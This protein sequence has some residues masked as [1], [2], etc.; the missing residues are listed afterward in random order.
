MPQYPS[1]TYGQEAF[2]FIEELDRLST[3]DDVMNAMEQ[4]LAPFGFENFIVAGIDPKRRFDEQVLANRWPSEFFTQYTR[5]NYLLFSPIARW[6]RR[7][8]T[9]FEWSEASYAHERDP[10]ALEVM[11]VAARFRIKRGFVVPIHGLNGY[12][13]AVSMSGVDLE[14]PPAS[15]PAI[16]LM[17]L[18]AFDHMRRLTGATSKNIPSLTQREREVLTWAAQ[19][20]SASEIAEIL[21]ITKRTVDEH[22]QITVRKLGA[23][24]RTHAVA[25]ALRER[26]IDI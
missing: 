13:A 4:A 22:T 3:T 6:C 8:T 1:S 5:E 25:I 9:P 2:A 12:E 24:N 20:K 10:R 18:Y 11:R 26:I 7:W 14:I 19:G 16:H 15:K 21:K 23:K 17:A